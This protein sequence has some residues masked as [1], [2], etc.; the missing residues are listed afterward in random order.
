MATGVAVS[1]MEGVRKAR[2]WLLGLG[3]V[4]I[5]VGTLALGAAV[6]ATIA[7]VI[8]F[9]WL[10]LVAGAIEVGYAFSQPKWGGLILHVVNG[11]LGVVAGFILVLHPAAG[12]LTLTLLMAMFFMIAGLF[13]IVTALLMRYPHWGWVLL[14]GLIT[15]VLGVLIWRQM[16]GAALWI[17][18]MF[19]GID[20][21]FVGWSWVMLALAL[22]TGPGQAYSARRGAPPEAMRWPSVPSGSGPRCRRHRNNPTGSWRGIAGGSP[23][24]SRTQW[25]GR[26]RW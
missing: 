17:I 20:L 8:F 25:R 24:R 15:F 19:V 1:G 10:L 22:R 6:F 26:S 5:L 18:G 9:G 23:R 2:G 16:P 4:L 14:N 7:S 3:I 21:I 13:R 11:V 12:A